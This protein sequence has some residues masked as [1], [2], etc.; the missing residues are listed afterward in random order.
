MANC[1]HSNQP[2]QTHTNLSQISYLRIFLQ[3]LHHFIFY[4][5]FLLLDFGRLF[6]CTQK[7]ERRRKKRKTKFGQVWNDES[8][9]YNMWMWMKFVIISTRLNLGMLIRRINMCV[10]LCVVC[11]YDSRLYVCPL[12]FLF[13][14]RTIGPTKT[15]II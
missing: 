6:L 9:V 13:V 7:R 3:L 12:Y 2:Y 14:L 5:I 10:C 15:K 4:G 8:Y 11:L 1:Q